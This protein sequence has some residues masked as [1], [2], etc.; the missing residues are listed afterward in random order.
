M[1]TLTVTMANMG[2]DSNVRFPAPLPGAPIFVI[3][4]GTG[5]TGELLARTVLAQFRVQAPIVIVGNV[6]SLEEVDAAVQQAAAAQGSILHTMVNKRLR[7]L[8]VKRANEKGVFAFD[9]AG[10]L[11]QHLSEE[12]EQQPLGVP[13]LYRQQQIAYFRRVE[14]IDFTVSHDDGKRAEELLQADIVLLGPSRSGKTPL[15]MYLAIIGWKVSN[16]PIVPYVEPPPELFQVDK[17][18]VVALQ[19]A[20]AQLMAHRKW[21]QQRLGTSGEGLYTNRDGIIEELRQYNHFV[22]RHGFSTVD[23]TDKPIETSG[24]E[25]VA[26]VAARV[27]LPRPEDDMTD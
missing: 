8:I 23:V 10:P 9:L 3:S 16:I 25:V 26:S 11:I 19:I 14:A 1:S 27:P 12:L 6:A 21:R 5:A 13:G 15:S 17:R 4:G 18:R 2:L 22:Y 7:E 20:P 24:D